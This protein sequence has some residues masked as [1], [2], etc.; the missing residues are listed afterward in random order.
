MSKK[1]TTGI[2]I[3]A[4]A[5]AIDLIPMLLQGLT[6]DANLSAWFL[7]IVTGFMISTSNLKINAALKGA[8]L[9]L[10]CFLPSS[11]IIGWKKPLSLI[12]I[13]IMTIV[14]GSLAGHLYHK[15]IRDEG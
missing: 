5:G 10:L 7:W 8:L 2:I 4:L 3:G 12:P 9:A 6:W 15:L 11:F 14:L 1:I 13:L